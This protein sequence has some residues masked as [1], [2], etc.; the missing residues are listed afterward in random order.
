MSK[1]PK[2]PKI[3]T[4]IGP[5]ILNQH[6]GSGSFATVFSAVDTRTKIEYAIKVVLRSSF[7]EKEVY[8][9]FQMEIRVLHQMRHQNI[10]QFID[11]LQ[12]D[13]YIYVVLELCPNG[14]L[15]N[16][17]VKRKFLSESEAKITFKQIING[18]NY[19]HQVGAMHRDLKPENILLDKT[20]MAKISDFGF[21]RYAPKT[22]LVSTYCGTTSYASPECL[23]KTPY[24][25]RKSDIWSSGV[26]LYA[27]VTGQLPWTDKNHLTN[28]IMNCEYTVPNYL[29]PLLQSLIKS[30]LVADPNQRPTTEDILNHEWLQG[31]DTVDLPYEQPRGVSLKYLDSFFNI[32]IPEIKLTVE[33][34]TSNKIMNKKEKKKNWTVKMNSFK[35]T[36]NTSFQKVIV[37]TQNMPEAQKIAMPNPMCC[38]RCQ[39]HL[40]SIQPRK[41]MIP[42]SAAEIAKRKKNAFSRR[43]WQIT[44]SSFVLDVKQVSTMKNIPKVA[45][46]SGRKPAP[47]MKIP[48]IKKPNV[49][50]MTV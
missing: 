5:Y 20:D 17:I 32:D 36:L 47:V 41:L 35:S 7:Q 4:N 9:H 33:F 45:S 43:S 10:V 23:S 46:S 30:I 11:L 28:Q 8:E 22:I 3:P 21:A 18:L 25:G 27:M 13:H 42:P 16:Y 12:D 49:P 29:S 37:V 34:D 1:E 50:K 39:S 6:L 44:E 19:I 24:D 38:P 40:G 31:A 26:I 2:P 48:T 14:D 15:F